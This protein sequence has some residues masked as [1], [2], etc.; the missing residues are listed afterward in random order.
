MSVTYYIG[1]VDIATT[2][3]VKVSAS[4]GLLSRPKFSAPD[5]AKWPGYHGEVIDLSRRTFE[6]RKI[7]LDC[8]ISATTMSGFLEKIGTFLSAM[9]TP[10]TIRLMVVVD[11]EKPLVYEVYLSSGIDIQKQWSDGLNVGTFTIELTEPA[12][13]KRVVKVTGSSLS[14]TM[15]SSKLVDIFW[16]DGTSTRDISGTSAA[17]THTYPTSD[18][19]YAIVAGAIDEIT[20]FSTSGT[21]IW[22]KL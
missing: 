20:G 17:S 10:G 3:G 14:I 11:T 22:S 16:G 15:T 5:S 1:G 2:Y 7:R 18:T 12:P 6:S 4:E 19:Y 8:F 9:D 13:L 21:I